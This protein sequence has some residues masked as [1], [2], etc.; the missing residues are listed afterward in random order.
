LIL[1][2][3]YVG[4][5][6][7]LV[8]GWLA[9]NVETTDSGATNVSLRILVAANH[10]EG[11]FLQSAMG[12]EAIWRSHEA[13]PFSR[14]KLIDSAT[15]ENAT[16]VVPNNASA[17]LADLF[18]VAKAKSASVVVENATSTVLNNATPAVAENANATYAPIPAS[19]AS[20]E[21]S[22]NETMNM[23]TVSSSAGT[24]PI[25]TVANFRARC[26]TGRLAWVWFPGC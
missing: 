24:M 5:A 20:A 3:L 1:Q 23:K 12:H 14:R 9:G 6:V 2:V 4:I 22:S 18:K 26:C 17:T 16:Y 25:Q 8:N 15:A 10:E 7:L 19:V 11:I 21:L 13:Q